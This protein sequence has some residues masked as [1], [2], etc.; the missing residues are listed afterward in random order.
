MIVSFT[1]FQPKCHQINQKIEICGM[2][3]FCCC[4]LFLCLALNFTP[5]ECIAA[6]AVSIVVEVHCACAKFLYLVRARV[7]PRKIEFSTH[8]KNL[9]EAHTHTQQQQKVL[10]LA[11]KSLNFG[12]WCVHRVNNN[13]VIII[14]TIMRIFRVKRR[15]KTKLDPKRRK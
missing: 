5:P 12:P 3:I 9:I 10:A 2:H 14:I 1:T 13:V 8:C 7:A 15:F 11:K 4:L 6:A